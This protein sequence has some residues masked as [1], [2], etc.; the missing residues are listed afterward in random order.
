MHPTRDFLRERKRRTI[1]SSA[2]ANEI[3]FGD[4][5]PRC[6]PQQ[7]NDLVERALPSARSVRS[8]HRA[9]SAPLV[10]SLTA[11]YGRLIVMPVVLTRRRSGVSDRLPAPAGASAHW[12]NRLVEKLDR[13]RRRYGRRDAAASRRN[14]WLKPCNSHSQ[15]GVVLAGESS[16]ENIG[17][18]KA[19]SVPG[20]EESSWMIRQAAG[21]PMGC[22]G[23]R[24]G[25]G[26]AA[27]R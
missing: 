10:C 2:P 11:C 18:Q 7:A 24:V 3:R 23:R 16:R 5:A 22:C 4:G 15:T 27:C 13:R 12:L 26:R 6:S 1:A 25:A 17:R 8:K 21:V 20:V 9:T 14:S 19:F